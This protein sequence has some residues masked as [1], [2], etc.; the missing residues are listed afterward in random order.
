MVDVSIIIVC[1]DR[2]DNLYPCLESIRRTTV[3]VSYEVLVV[4]YMYDRERLA[5]AR[6]DFPWVTFIVSD[7]IRGFSEN[8]NLALKHA[9]GRFCFVLNDDTEIPDATVDMLTEDFMA[10]PEG[11][12]I[13][14]PT[15]LNADGS[16]QLRGRP[17]YPALHYVLQQ[18]H[19]FSEPADNTAGQE[20]AA[21]I[22]GRELFRTWNI[23]GAAFLIQTDIFRE[24]G[25]FDERFFFTPEDIALGTL[26]CRKGYR[27]YV[28]SSAKV[29]HKWRSTASRIMCATR[30]AAVRGSLMHF[31]DF[32]PVR[33][34]LLAIPVWCA[35]FAKRTKA[36]ALQALRPSPKHRT[37]LQ[38]FRN[39]TRSIFTKKTPK[40]IFT[41]YYMEL[42]RS[43]KD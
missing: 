5:K 33:Y 11:T 2:P 20:P 9:R 13:V 42:S 29:V 36:A 19:L 34:L 39:I 28:D 8:N 23:T 12:A 6:E 31:S 15:L 18:W 32:R 25:W 38:T 27:L 24:L 40:E 4:A 16:L 14:S 37:E 43:I 26:A 41:R 22:D 30:P 35:E 17:P 21:T 7:V 1:M 3:R 10:L